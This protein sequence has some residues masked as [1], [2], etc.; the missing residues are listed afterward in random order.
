[1]FCAESVLKNLD[2]N[3]PCVG[4]EMKKLILVRK[5]FMLMFIVISLIVLFHAKYDVLCSCKFVRKLLKMSS[6]KAWNTNS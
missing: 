3:F 1:M 5:M 6:I 4:N 2:S